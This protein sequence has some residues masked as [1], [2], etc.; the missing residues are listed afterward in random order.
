MTT[1]MGAA[2]SG[3]AAH[4]VSISRRASSSRPK[5]W[6]LSAALKYSVPG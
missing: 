2:P 1:V 5:K 4:T 3:V 6:W